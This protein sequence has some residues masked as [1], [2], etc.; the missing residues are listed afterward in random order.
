MVDEFQDVL[1][2]FAALKPWGNDENF[3]EL[4]VFHISCSTNQLEK[5]STLD[6]NRSHN[7]K[8][9]LGCGISLQFTP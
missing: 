6:V 3:Y 2:C 1:G 4:H 5:D 8:R 7:G 9:R